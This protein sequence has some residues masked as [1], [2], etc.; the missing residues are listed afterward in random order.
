[1]T[2]STPAG[3]PAPA[4]PADRIADVLVAQLDATWCDHCHPGDGDW[5]HRTARAVLA[6]LTADR[7]RTA[8]AALADEWDQIA[9]EQTRMHRHWLA[10]RD[11]ATARAARI[12][13]E[14][15]GR[16]AAQL[17]TLLEET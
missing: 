5:A 16:C 8:L 3:A 2:G 14:M 17:R 4:G 9:A 6:D 13:A 1:M 10:R 15:A 12:R 11:P 7:L